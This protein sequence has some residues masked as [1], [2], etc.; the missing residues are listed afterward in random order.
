MYFRLPQ[1]GSQFT[2]LA[3]IHVLPWSVGHLLHK[4]H[5][6]Y[7]LLWQLHE[8]A[9][10]LCFPTRSYSYPLLMWTKLSNL[11]TSNIFFPEQ[12]IFA[13]VNYLNSTCGAFCSLISVYQFRC[14]F[15]A[16]CVRLP[17]VC[18]LAVR[19]MQ[20]SNPSQVSLPGISRELESPATFTNLTITHSIQSDVSTGKDPDF[21][22]RFSV[23]IH[24]DEEQARQPM[25]ENSKR[26]V[27][28]SDIWR[29]KNL[30]SNDEPQRIVACAPA[31]ENTPF[32]DL[33][34]SDCSV[35]RPACLRRRY[36][37]LA[38]E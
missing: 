35:Y 5:N 28:Q 6:G 31:K 9:V 30:F 22:R 34:A 37:V 7:I 26:W 12:R 10:S 33:G 38:A 3:C 14:K 11:Y 13:E 27:L 1:N 15:F 17:W 21:W 25:N 24:R 4:K 29:M 16:S 8:T 23:A 2:L 32:E 19:K 20:Q 18:L 36:C